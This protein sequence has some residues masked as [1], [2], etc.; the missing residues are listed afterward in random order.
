MDTRQEKAQELA[1]RGRVV[2]QPDHW[3]VF[4]LTSTEKYRVTLDP[5]SCSCPDYE[6]RQEPCKHVL[7]VRIDVAQNGADTPCA[8]KPRLMVEEEPIKRQ[9]PT[10]RQDWPSYC[11]AQKNE[12]D[13]FLPLLSD[14]CAGIVEPERKPGRGR[15]PASLAAQAFAAI[16][17]VFTGMSGRRFMSDL[18]DVQVKGFVSEAVSP[19]SIA[20]FLES[21]EA[22]PILTAILTQSS[23]PLKA[24]EDEF[25]VDSSGFSASRFEKW[26]NVKHGKMESKQWWAKA[27]VMAGTRTHVITS[28]IIEDQHSND[29]PYF[30]PLVKATAKNFTIRQ[31]TADKAYGSELNFQ[32]VED[33]GGTAY[34]AFRKSATGW[35]GGIF[36]R[37]YHEFCL[38]K[39]EYLRCYHRRSNVESV[40]SAVKR[41]YGDSVRSRTRTAMKNE[42]ICKLV[43]HNLSQLI[44]LMYELGLDLNFESKR[45]LDTKYILKFP[46]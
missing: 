41:V 35:I 22:T 2:R 5:V 15:R 9:R 29:A 19:A 14:L 30:A 21:E 45:E 40:F 32:T 20:R 11:A 8:K 12:K 42:V 6:L 38:N 25:A 26:Y 10:Y 31:A 43:C 27:H 44:H 36:E 37:M 18:R 4:S 17:K 1:S 34:I 3:L 24:L 46:I 23:L 28:V 16:F 13:E 7:A 39:E 33:C